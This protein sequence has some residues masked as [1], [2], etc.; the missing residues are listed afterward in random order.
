MK[1]QA[2]TLEGT[3]PKGY[4]TFK[5]IRVTDG[6]R[7]TF[8]GAMPVFDLIDKHF[9]A[10]VASAGLSPEVLELV[11][12]N[13]AV[14]RKT[15]PS[16][17]QGI[18]D[19]IV[20]QA[21]RN[22]PWAFNSIVLYSTS[23]L[24]FEGVSIG[25]ASAGEAR[26]KDA[27]SVGEGLHRCLAWAVSLDL[28]RV[29]GVKRPEISEDALK[30]IQQATIPVVVVEEKSLKRQ[31]TDF[32]KLNQQKPLTST[33]L[34]LTDDTV[35]SELTRMVIRDIKLFEGRIDVNNASVGAKS[36]KLLSFAQL[37]FVVASYL[38]GKKTRVRKAIER[39][40]ERI[41][42]EQGKETVRAE[43]REVFTQVATRFGGLERLHR[44]QLPVQTATDLLRT[45][46]SETLLA[47]TAAWRALFVALN[48]AKNA[49][50]DAETAIDRIKRNSAV[51]WTRDADFFKGTLVEVDP[52]TGKPT[53]KLLSSR[54][55]IDVAA[56][57]LAA[58]MTK[59]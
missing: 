54:E 39:D 23:P 22:D 33:V 57:K 1:P 35:L 25:M 18:V 41:V 56:D 3:K 15:N 37:R 50:V 2:P 32:S 12:T 5:A 10:P 14:Q 7:V 31:K 36:D 30:R 27:L 16:H 42:A 38:L 49:G 55:S 28:A 4:L 44:N 20:G 6:D 8:I 17:V 53:G 48:E 58:V 40:V 51:T 59:S 47:S 9:I 34:N 13:G 46:R 19:Y 11:L 43:L 26:A 29:K 45:I 52:G 21:E 24:E